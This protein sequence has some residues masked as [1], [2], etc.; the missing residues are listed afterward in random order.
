MEGG[1]AR[2]SHP[3]TP[4]VARNLRSLHPGLFFFSSPILSVSPRLRRRSECRRWET[5]LARGSVH[6]AAAGGRQGSTPFRI[7]V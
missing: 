7:I 3:H 4:E 2:F 5:V 6:G 1:W